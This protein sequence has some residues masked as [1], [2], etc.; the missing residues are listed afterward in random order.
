M[1]STLWTAQDS[2]TRSPHPPCF[3]L[4]QHIL[5]SPPKSSSLLPQT[6]STQLHPPQRHQRLQPIKQHLN[7]TG[8]PN[9]PYHTSLD[10]KSL[11][12]SC[13]MK[14]SL[15]TTI[16]HFHDKPH[17]LPPT[18]LLPP[19]NPL[20]PFVLTTPTLNSTANSTHKTLEERW[21]PHLW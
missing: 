12:T 14:E 5:V 6:L 7:T 8:L 18:Y 2:Q 10:I 15:S 9:F 1:A 13:D 3:F 20:Y 19:S 4:L 17:L 21:D 11:Y 16:L